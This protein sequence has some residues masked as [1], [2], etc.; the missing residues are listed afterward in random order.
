MSRASP[1]IDLSNQNLSPTL[2]RPILKA[3]QHQSCLLQLDLSSNLIR[4]EGVKY[5]SQTLAT[6]K[7]LHKLDI[8]GNMVTKSGLEF[9]E[10]AL[11]KS[12]NPNEIRELI[13]S[14]NPITSNTLKIVSSLCNSRRVTMLSMS[15]CDLTHSTELDVIASI[16]SLDISYNQLTREGFIG[17]LRKLNPGVIE[18][19][20]FERCCSAPDT[21]SSIAQFISSGCYGSLQEIN[22]AG[23]NFDENEVLDMLRC[24]EKCSQLKSLNLS[25]QRQLTF[26]TFKYLLFSL[27]CPS[28]EYISLIGCDNLKSTSNMFNFRNIDIQRSTHIRCIQLSL[29]AQATRLEFIGTMSELWDVVCDRRGK[30]D[31]DS[32]IL[33]LIYGEDRRQ[34]PLRL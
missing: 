17:F 33:R 1:Y 22:L 28:L 11:G 21:G 13:L 12:R 31:H 18:N 32:N 34:H 3:L 25:Y 30:I 14:F 16:K 4:D 26:L 19:L 23:L 7:Q 9:L 20:N 8:S 27:E 5:L 2:A 24:L 15:Y 6:I 29:P 10:N